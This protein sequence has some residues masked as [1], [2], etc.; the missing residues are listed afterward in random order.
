MYYLDSLVANSGN[1]LLIVIFILLVREWF[2]TKNKH[3]VFQAVLSGSIAW[4]IGFLIKNFFYVPRPF[5]LSG[6]TPL[7]PFLFDG[8]FP[9]NHAALAFGLSL[10][11]FY[12]DRK[13]GL[14]LFSISVLIAFSRVIGGV[15]TEADILG[16][17]TVGILSSIIVQ[18]FR[19]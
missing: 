4:I 2:V 10:P 15:H 19:G 18:K 1:L 11:V 16:G 14:I 9:S 5:I 3:L 7:I 12:K 8:S 13:I 6:Q 17:V